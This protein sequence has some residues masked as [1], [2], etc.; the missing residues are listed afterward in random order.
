MKGDARSL[1]YS[2]CG[3]SEAACAQ[4]ACAHLGRLFFRHAAAFD[5]SKGRRL[6][7]SNYSAPEEKNKGK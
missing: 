6:S 5:A 3:I 4:G 1:D 2:S 7:C